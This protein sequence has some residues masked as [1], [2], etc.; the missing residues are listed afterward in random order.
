M[1]TDAFE[2]ALSPRVTAAQMQLG[3]AIPG[4][5]ISEADLQT[6]GLPRGSRWGG[7]SKATAATDLPQ[8]ESV[9]PPGF[10]AP[11]QGRAANLGPPAHRIGLP[12]WVRPCDDMMLADAHEKELTNKQAYHR[13]DNIEMPSLGQMSGP[14]RCG[15]DQRPT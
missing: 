5:E 1:Q 9:P 15:K 3:P 10:P 8:R 12:R 2:A 6:L 11:F 14:A 4:Q 7:V 13:S